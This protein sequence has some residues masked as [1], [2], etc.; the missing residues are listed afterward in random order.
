[1]KILN[2][3]ILLVILTVLTFACKQSKEVTP[4]ISETPEDIIP[5]DLEPDVLA[6]LDSILY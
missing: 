5:T 2:T 4:D 1:M 3:L 6:E